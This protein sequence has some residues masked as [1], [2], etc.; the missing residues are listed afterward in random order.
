MRLSFCTMLCGVA[1][2]ATSVQAGQSTFDSGDEGWSIVSFALL[3]SDNYSVMGTYTASY[4]STG[5]NPGGYI[6]TNDPDG[7]DFTFAAPTAFLGSH[8]GATSGTLSYDLA[9]PSLI[10][11]QTSDVILTGG[12]MV[13]RLLYIP[14]TPFV[15]NGSFQTVNV[16]LSASSSW[17]VDTTNGAAPTAEQFADVLANLSGLYI[18]GEYSDTVESASLDNVN[19]TIVPAPGCL[20]AA[21]GFAGVGLIR[22][23]RER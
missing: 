7:G 17:H 8:A 23:R 22:R 14:A 20:T 10:D 5:G 11:Y 12:N 2:L 16:D 6:Y 3:A 21:M 19:L 1:S 4:S 9:N 13:A 18:R 15:P